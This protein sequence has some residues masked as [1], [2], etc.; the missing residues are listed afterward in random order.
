MGKIKMKSIIFLTILLALIACALTASHPVNTILDNMKTNG[1]S[2]KEI[3]K[4]FHYLHQKQ[5]SLNSDE[6][7]KRYRIFKQNENWIKEENTKLGKTVYGTT[8]FS[9][10]THEEFVKNHLTASEYLEKKI[11]EE[12]K[13]KSLRFLSEK[14]I[15]EHHHVHEHYHISDD[16]NHHHHHH[17]DNHDDHNKENKGEEEIIN[18]WRKWD[19]PA[20][21]QG[22][23]GSCWAF[24]S[25][26]ALE[27]AYH[28][29]KGKYTAFSEQY[30]VDCD[31]DGAWGCKGGYSDEAFKWI[32]NHGIVS[33]E[34]GPYRGA[35]GICRRE[36][37]K[38]YEYKILKSYKNYYKGYPYY[39]DGTWDELISK[40]PVVVYMDASFR[41]F[42]F[43][44]PRELEP[45]RPTGC[46]QIS[47][48]VVAVAITKQDGKEYIIGRN[49]WG[50]SWGHQGYFKMPKD[51]NCSMD[52][53]AW[54]PEVYDGHVPDKKPKP[55]PQPESKTCI[56]LFKYST[57]HGKPHSKICDSSDGFSS[58]L[59][60]IR[61]PKNVPAGFSVRAFQYPGCWGYGPTYTDSIIID[62]SSTKIR[63][64]G[65]KVAFDSIAFHK[66]AD[67]GCVNFYNK[68]CLEGESKFS[69]CNDIKDSQ[70]VNLAGLTSV[71]SLILDDHRIE[72]FTVYSEPHYG[73]IS[74][75][76]D[77]D[78]PIYQ[79]GTNKAFARF[80]EEGKVRSIKLHLK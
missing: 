75:S 38:P 2:Q 5:Y 64:H 25:I 79:M 60:A 63:Y 77:A 16:L 35:G 41:G 66:P 18:D 78:Q 80:L 14:Q 48:A 76:I 54:L 61:F 73:G 58:T 44:R 12:I 70:D 69:I 39:S 68:S 8:Q 15:H 42:G 11:G 49:S 52:K 28:R 45:L 22:S 74:H 55:E 17:H 50:E 29:L 43:Y 36:D 7:I 10:L 62:E 4:T 47:H 51:N 6:G 13:E 33:E 53:Y 59:K 9:D 26:G 56:E 27:N 21:N 37:D 71:K 65:K 46:G 31:K 1:E 72:R 3:F 19:A 23:C 32:I 24:A 30:L 20:K 40:G 67:K 34:H 57:F